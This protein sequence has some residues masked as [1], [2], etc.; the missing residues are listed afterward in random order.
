MAKASVRDQ[1]NVQCLVRLELSFPGERFPHSPLGLLREDATGE[2]P[3]ATCVKRSVWLQ[4]NI[5]GYPVRPRGKPLPKWPSAR[6][7]VPGG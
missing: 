2:Y 7:V 5:E 4:E 1:E 6:T 3:L